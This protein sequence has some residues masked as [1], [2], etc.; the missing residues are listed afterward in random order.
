MAPPPQPGYNQWGPPP[1]PP[2]PQPQV[3]VTQ[4]PP[5]QPQNSNAAG[6]GLMAWYVLF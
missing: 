4:A 6:V 2:Q 1:P 5:A 3:F